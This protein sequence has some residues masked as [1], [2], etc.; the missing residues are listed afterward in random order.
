[1]EKLRE[2]FR[3]PEFGLLFFFLTMAVFSWPF[4]AGYSV[5]SMFVYI[6]IA[7]GAI[8]VLLFFISGNYAKR[9]SDD[10]DLNGKNDV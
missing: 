2:L 4:F 9:P 10:E 5:I 3:L 8:I 1:M 7:W 6:F